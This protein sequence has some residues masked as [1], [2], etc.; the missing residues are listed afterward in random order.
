MLARDL[1]VH[2]AM[3]DTAETDMEAEYLR[4][5]IALISRLHGACEQDHEEALYEIAWA[6][7]DL[8]K[9]Q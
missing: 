7:S 9:L 6:K 2:R 8:A 5:E 4:D 1:A 3:L